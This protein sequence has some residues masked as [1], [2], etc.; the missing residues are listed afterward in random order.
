M[1]D[2]LRK[3]QAGRERD[4]FRPQRRA[5]ET[6]ADHHFAAGD[7]ADSGNVCVVHAQPVNREAVC[8]ALRHRTQHAGL[9]QTQ[10]GID[11]RGDDFT[12]GQAQ[13]RDANE[14]ACAE[15]AEILDAGGIGNQ[16][17]RRDAH[18][19]PQHHDLFRR[20]IDR[21]HRARYRIQYAYA[22]AAEF[23]GSLV[24]GA[25]R[26]NGDHLTHGEIGNRGRQAVR[27]YRRA[28]RVMY[29]EAVD[30]YARKAGDG[31]DH[32]DTGLAGA[33]DAAFGDIAGASYATLGDEPGATDA[34]RLG[35]RA[36]DTPV[37]R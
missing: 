29:F 15:E 22:H 7:G 25:A 10:H 18:G 20:G 16:G 36:T 2:V 33:A 26:F 5:V 8:V 31:A 13:P 12:A 27:H 34:A 14:G 17:L 28:A 4:A 37:D 3:A 11:A 23:A 21:G 24:A 6:A 30:A 9:I 19:L 1:V 32:A 35:A